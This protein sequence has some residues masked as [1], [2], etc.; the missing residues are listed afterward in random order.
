MGSKYALLPF[1]H[2]VLRELDFDSAIDAFAGSSCVAYLLKA[3]GKRVL[4]NDFLNFGATV[5]AALVENPGLRLS[6]DALSELLR[7]AP[8][9]ERFIER[10]FGGIFFAPADLRF[11]DRVCW[12]LRALEHRHEHAL[13]LA[14]LIRS[15]LKRQPRG[16]FTVAGSPAR[17][18]DDR[19]DLKL[20]LHAHFIEQVAVYNAASFDNGRR[21]RARHGDAFELGTETADLVYLDPPYVPRADDNCYVK[22]YHFVEGLSCYW[23]GLTI[24]HD[25]KVRKIEKRFTPFSYRRT[26]LAAFDRLFRQFADSIQVLSY[27]SNAYPALPVLIELMGRYKRRIDVHERPHRYHFGT[28]SAARRRQV[29]EYLIVGC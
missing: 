5:A 12:N 22:R 6:A 16:V 15:C 7:P 27:S 9:R 10:T 11:L 26:A 3:M 17:Y 23:R 24:R 13:A 25:T 8:G 28:H 14:A 2:G 21:N 20:S 4:A 1:L 19:R 18:D 29:S